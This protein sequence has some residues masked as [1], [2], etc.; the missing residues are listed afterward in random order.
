MGLVRQLGQPFGR[1]RG[2]V[3]QKTPNKKHFLEKKG[4]ERKTT[5]Q[6]THS[7]T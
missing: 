1:E 3:T 2:L 5:E 4:L 7:L 6:G